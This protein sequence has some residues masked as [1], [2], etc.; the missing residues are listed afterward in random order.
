MEQCIKIKCQA[1]YNISKIRTYL[2]DTSAH[3]L[4]HALLHSHLDYCN[5][6]LTGLPNHLVHK[7][8]LVQN[9]AARVLCQVSKREHIRTVL[10]QL[11]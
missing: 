5:N 9:S 7:L 1:V 6:L 2:G 3:I 4:I 11:Y 10:K 8:Q